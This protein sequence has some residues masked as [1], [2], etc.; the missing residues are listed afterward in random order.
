MT[1]LGLT[2]VLQARCV[3]VWASSGL[4]VRASGD[5]KNQQPA[6]NG[7]PKPWY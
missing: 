1:L 6:V 3:T 7:T 5:A 4:I 2:S